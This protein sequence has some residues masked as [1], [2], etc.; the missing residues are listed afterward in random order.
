MRYPLF[1]IFPTFVYLYFLLVSM[2]LPGTLIFP[3]VGVTIARP[4][5]LCPQIYIYSTTHEWRSPPIARPPFFM[6]GT[7]R[8]T[9]L[10]GVHH[11]PTERVLQYSAQ[12]LRANFIAFLFVFGGFYIFEHGRPH[13]DEQTIQQPRVHVVK[14]VISSER[15]R[16]V[17][18]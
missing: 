13:I 9:P 1:T 3:P 2:F 17:Q 5:F 6:S 16:N 15:R 18:P 10:D 8:L 14:P 12:R 7:F 4:P 11:L